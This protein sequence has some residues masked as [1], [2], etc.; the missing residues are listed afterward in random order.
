MN[1]RT[2][3][4]QMALAMGGTLSAS[5]LGFVLN[6]CSTTTEQAGTAVAA[7]PQNPLFLPPQKQFVHEVSEIIIPRTD[8]PGAIDAEVPD[9]IYMMIQDCYP[10]E[11]QQHFTASI[12]KALTECEEVSGTPFFQLP[13]EDKIKFVKSLDKEAHDNPKDKNGKQH[14]FRTLKELTLLG[15][16]TSKPGATQAM[17][18]VH[19]P[20]RYEGCTTREPGE[21]GW[22]T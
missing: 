6:G 19:V 14:F 16:F 8:T 15:Y 3:I 11:E 20:G 17:N 12:S 5:T 7:S 18:Y 4:K 9:F 2:S 21:K 13:E 10:E 1:R 22:A